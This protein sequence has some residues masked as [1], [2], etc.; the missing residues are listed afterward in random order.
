MKWHSDCHLCTLTLPVNISGFGCCA[1]SMGLDVDKEIIDTDTQTSAP[2][3]KANKPSRQV[4]Q[5]ASIL[6]RHKY[7][8]ASS[9]VVDVD[10]T[11]TVAEVANPSEATIVASMHSYAMPRNM[12][13]PTN[14]ARLSAV[15]SADVRANRETADHVTKRPVS[16]CY[17]VMNLWLVKQ[18]VFNSVCFVRSD[19]HFVFFLAECRRKWLNQ[20]S[21][22]LLYFAL[23]AFP[24]LSLVFVVSVLNLS[25][26]T[27]FPACTDVNGTV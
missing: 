15:R 17:E 7:R 23:F 21:F 9:S 4:S 24:G 10:K 12:C 14:V 18:L 20:C 27:Y 2:S 8:S 22:V 26:V 16:H 6:R 5:S 19:P 25:S 11:T 1:G 13:K 3:V